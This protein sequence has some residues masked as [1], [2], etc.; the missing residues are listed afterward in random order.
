VD[1][2]HDGTGL[3]ATRAR[4]LALHG[5][6]ASLRVRPAA[7]RGTCATVTLPLGLHDGRGAPHAGAAAAEAQDLAA[8]DARVVA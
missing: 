4:L 2:A 7:G 6:D 8:P 1:G 3:G 5:A